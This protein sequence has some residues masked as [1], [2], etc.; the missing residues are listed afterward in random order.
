MGRSTQ[1]DELFQLA[2]GEFTAARNALAKTL[3]GDAAKEARALRK[4]NAVAWSA[5]NLYWKARAQWDALM[6]AGRALREAQIGALKGK[7]TDVRGATEKHREALGHAVKRAHAIAQAAGVHPD[8][9]QL[10]RMLDALSLAEALPDDVG[11]FS[12]VVQPS[13]FDALTG[14]KPVARVPTKHEETQK[15]KDADAAK[16]K[17]EAE[18]RLGAATDALN[19]ARDKADAAK[20]AFNRAEADV[21]DAEREV[22]AAGEQLSKLK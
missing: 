1:L 10:A 7:K 2:P 6:K 15:K 14:V 5:N 12:D 22:E 20:R 9:D 11:R 8:T 4:P 21:R 17:K 16:R 18:A 19:D 3:T 13:G